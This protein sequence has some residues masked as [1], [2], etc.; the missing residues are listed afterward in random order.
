MD[1]PQG[2]LALGP[3][4]CGTEGLRPDYARMMQRVA[5]KL[6]A[7]VDRRLHCHRLHRRR[8]QAQLLPVPGRVLRLSS[9][10]GR[11]AMTVI[12]ELKK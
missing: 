11:N 3:A 5:R 9:R 2:V 6:V 4:G 1:E 8:L 12:R 7:M 10:L